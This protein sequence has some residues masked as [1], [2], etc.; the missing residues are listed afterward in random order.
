MDAKYLLDNISVAVSERLKGRVRDSGV[1]PLRQNFLVMYRPWKRYFSGEAELLKEYQTRLGIP[2]SLLSF[3]CLK[4]C[5]LLLNL[6]LLLL[7]S[8]AD[9]W[10]VT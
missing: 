2:M 7:N 4:G 3:K 6:F 1:D 9:G 5:G 8:V 10:T